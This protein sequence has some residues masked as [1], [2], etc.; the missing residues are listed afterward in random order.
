MKKRSNWRSIAVLARL[1]LWA[2]K[3]CSKGRVDPIFNVL[4]STLWM[5]ALVTFPHLYH[6]S[7]LSQCPEKDPSQ[8]WKISPASMLSWTCRGPIWPKT[9]TFMPCLL[10]EISTTLSQTSAQCTDAQQLL[11]QMLL[12]WIFLGKTR[13]QRRHC[14]SNW[15]NTFST[16][17]DDTSTAVWR[18]V[19][20]SFCP[21]TGGCPLSGILYRNLTW[22]SV[23]WYEQ[24]QVWWWWWP[25]RGMYWFFFNM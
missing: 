19:M 8:W 21:G 1:Y 14:E 23:V 24:C 22:A 11:L 17:W 20:F 13:C 2:K 4:L 3:S 7:A 15:T 10:L 25:R 5:E 6:H 12:Q 18:R 9:V 16:A